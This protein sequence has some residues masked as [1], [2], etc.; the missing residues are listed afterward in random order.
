MQA[1]EEIKIGT[2][3]SLYVTTYLL[4]GDS[5]YLEL[6]A[7]GSGGLINSD[8]YLLKFNGYK[9]INNTPYLHC[10]LELKNDELQLGKCIEDNPDGQ[11]FTPKGI[12]YSKYLFQHHNHNF[13]CASCSTADFL[14]T[15]RV[16][17]VLLQIRML[18]LDTKLI[19]NMT[20]HD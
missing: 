5:V 16:L 7:Q 3:N 20:Y 17:A 18:T 13:Y 4:K 6:E 10:D 1:D 19:T 14:P 8:W 11:S 2:S 12:I 15:C 9:R